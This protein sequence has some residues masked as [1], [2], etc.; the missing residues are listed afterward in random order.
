MFDKKEMVAI[1]LSSVFLAFALSLGYFLSAAT[2]LIE[3]FNYFGFFLVT[4]AIVFLI[5]LINSLA[6]KI[7]AYFF[8]S[9]LKIR[10]WEVKRW[11]Y[12]PGHYFRAPLSA[13]IM[14]PLITSFVSLG[15]FVWLTPLVFDAEPGKHRVAKRHGSKT[16][17]YMNESHIGLIAAFGLLA[18]I[19]FA[20][21]GNLVGFPEFASLSLFFIMF[22]ILPLSDLDGTKIFFGSKVL[23]F[24]ML[25][26]SL[27]GFLVGLALL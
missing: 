4:L 20:Y 8:D 18:N 14:M 11:G 7:A 9:D 16:F 27:I 25:V 22:N 1:G 21:I 2:G 23:W 6:K 13:G 3:D 10:L 24:I 12:K 5:L 17:Y 19:F 26:I 15:Y